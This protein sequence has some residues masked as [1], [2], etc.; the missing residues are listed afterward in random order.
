MLYKLECSPVLGEF[1]S[2][3]TSSSGKLGTAFY[4][5]IPQTYIKTRIL[6][7]KFSDFKWP[8]T[9]YP[10]DSVN[11]T[12]DIIAKI[13]LKLCGQTVR[14]MRLSSNQTFGAVLK[15]NWQFVWLLRKVTFKNNCERVILDI[16]AMPIPIFSSKSN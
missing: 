3:F 7:E 12:F 15:S 14:E 2:S 13:L 9:M 1:Y 5:T 11:K 16:Y 4:S 8:S 10:I 6:L